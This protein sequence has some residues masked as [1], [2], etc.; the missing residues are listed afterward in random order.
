MINAISENKR[1]IHFLRVR[2]YGALQPIYLLKVTIASSSRNGNV[3]HL[4][5]CIRILQIDSLTLL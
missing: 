4:S 5:T 1:F 3:L 2:C